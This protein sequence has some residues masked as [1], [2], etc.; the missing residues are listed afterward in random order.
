M[1]DVLVHVSRVIGGYIGIITSFCWNSH[2]PIEDCKMAYRKQKWHICIWLRHV[3]T[4]SSSVFLEWG[5]PSPVGATLRQNGLSLFCTIAITTGLTP[6]CS[7]NQT[8]QWIHPNGPYS[9]H[10]DP[11][12]TCSALQLRSEAEISFFEN[13]PSEKYAKYRLL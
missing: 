10:M 8:Y 13:E 9:N 12:I 2:Q 6:Q 3:Q 5:R 1:C 11:R 4:R 7:G